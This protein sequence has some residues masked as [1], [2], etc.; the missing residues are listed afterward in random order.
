MPT[1]LPPPKNFTASPDLI[2]AG[3]NGRINYQ[4][5]D[6]IKNRARFSE[7]TAWGISGR[8]WWDEKARQWCAEI[9]KKASSLATISA[10]VIEDL[11]FHIQK[12]YGWK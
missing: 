12:K 2:I 9:T 10:E 5:A 8:I 7:F 1:V 3:I 11:V 4:V 6:Q